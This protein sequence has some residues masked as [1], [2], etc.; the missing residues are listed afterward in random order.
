LNGVTVQP[1]SIKPLH[2]AFSWIAARQLPASNIFN[3]KID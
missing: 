2:K 1:F 3:P